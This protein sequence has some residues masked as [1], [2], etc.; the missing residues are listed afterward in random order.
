MYRVI[1]K[2][3]QGVTISEYF[4]SKVTKRCEGQRKFRYIEVRYSGRSY[5]IPIT[6][7]VWKAFGLKDK[8]SNCT[9]AE[10]FELDFEV[11][12]AIAIIVGAIQLQVKCDVLDGIEQS[13]IQAVNEKF[14]TMMRHPLREELERQAK[15]KETRLL[16]E[17]KDGKQ[18]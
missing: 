5:Y 14:A 6:A 1:S 12:D 8:I 17:P 13:V 18:E 16:E 4:E 10:S 9:D 3:P 2:L 15:I 7:E 11:G